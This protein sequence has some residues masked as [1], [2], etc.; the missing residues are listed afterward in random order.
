M[1][2]SRVVRTI[3][4]TLDSLLW[5]LDYSMGP[6]TNKKLIWASLESFVRRYYIPV[7]CSSVACTAEHN[8]F[9]IQFSWRS[10]E[11]EPRSRSY[12]CS[13]ISCS[14]AYTTAVRRDNIY[15]VP[16]HRWWKTPPSR[17]PGC[18][19]GTRRPTRR[20]LRVSRRPGRG[21]DSSPAE[22]PRSRP[23]SGPAFAGPRGCRGSSPA[24][25]MI[26]IIRCVRTHATAW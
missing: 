3:A 9:T 13:A 19:T 5:R 11:T 14:S 1:T 22:T 6:P 10:P 26:R 25:S 2:S 12:S 16:C 15:I 23:T 8:F 24:S 18:G 21:S 4:T 7:G 17:P 20:S